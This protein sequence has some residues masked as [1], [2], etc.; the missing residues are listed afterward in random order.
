MAVL[1]DSV[2]A[3]PAF[4]SNE[5]ASVGSSKCCWLGCGRPFTHQVEW[6]IG[7]ARVAGLYCQEHS[8]MIGDAGRGA[9]VRVASLP[10][11]R[12]PAE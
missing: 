11:L 3:R 6:L 1:A 9:Q 10:S 2:D 12:S 7:E 4:E 5:A 8:D